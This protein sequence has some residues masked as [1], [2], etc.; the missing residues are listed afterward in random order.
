MVP[1]AWLLT[2]FSIAIA[3]REFRTWYRSR[4]I[5][6]TS[7]RKDEFSLADGFEGELARRHGAP[8]RCA[9]SAKPGFE[10]ETLKCTGH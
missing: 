10:A 8:R 2:C 4:G 6:T 3:A 7:G 5:G 9:A 1:V